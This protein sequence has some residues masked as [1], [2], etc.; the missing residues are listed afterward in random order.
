ML[1]ALAKKEQAVIFFSDERGVRSDFHAGTTWG[2][3]AKTPIV[4]HTGKRFH[5]TCYRPSRPKE[6]CGS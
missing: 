6:N 4:A 5:L 3:R 2:I 1:R